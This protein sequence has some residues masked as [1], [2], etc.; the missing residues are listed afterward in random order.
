MRLMR[1]LIIIAIIIAA[2][3]AFAESVVTQRVVKVK[4]FV[5]G[6]STLNLSGK[7]N[8]AAM[9]ALAS[10]SEMAIYNYLDAYLVFPILLNETKSSFSSKTKTQNVSVSRRN[11]K[12]QWTE[13][14]VSSRY[15]FVAGN[16]RIKPDKATFKSSGMLSGTT[17]TEIEG[18][19][20]TIYDQL[21]AISGE[22]CVGALAFVPEKKGKNYKFN[23]NDN[24]FQAKV[25]VNSKGKATA[26]YKLP[27]DIAYP[28]YIENEYVFTNLYDYSLEIVGVGDVESGFVGPDQVEFHVTDNLGKFRFFSYD[29]V[30]IADDYLYLELDKDT[31]VQAVFG[32]FDASLKIIGKGSAT[33]EFTGQDEIEITANDSGSTF[34]Y[35]MVNGEKRTGNPLTISLQE[36]T[37]IQ[38]VFGTYAFRTEVIGDGSFDYEFIGPDSVKITVPE[39]SKLFRYFVVNYDRYTDRTILLD[40]WYDTRVKAVFGTYDFSVNVIGNGSVNVEFI[41][42]DTAEISVLE[43]EYPFRYYDVNGEKIVNRS[44]LLLYLQEDT[45]VEAVFGT[46]AFSLEI[47]GEGSAN[48][49]FT[50]P[51]EVE[52]KVPEGV[53]LFRYFTVNGE[54]FTDSSLS[55]SLEKD[56]VVKAVFG[57]YSLSIEVIGDGTVDYEF[58]GPDLVEVTAQGSGSTFRN[59]TVNGEMRTDNPLTISLEKDTLVKAIFGTYGLSV[60]IVGSGF[61]NVDFTDNET[62]NL[63]A[64]NGADE[65]QSFSWDGKVS[66]ETSLILELTKDTVVTATFAKTNYLVIDI[67]EGNS[68]S[69]WPHRISESGPEVENDACRTTELWLKFVPA[70]E[71]RMGSPEDE[72]GRGKRED[73]HRVTLTKGFYICVFEITRKQYELIT[74]ST[75]N[76]LPYIPEKEKDVIPAT[77]INFNTLR[78]TT[79]G[80]NWP[81]ND[82]VD[83]GSFMG[84]LRAK[85]GLRFDLPTEAQWEC[86]CRAT[87]TTA[88]NSGNNMDDE[89]FYLSEY[90]YYKKNSGRPM[91]VGKLKPNLLGLYDMH[92]NVWEWCLDWYTDNL[93]T[94]PVVDPVG[95]ETGS[96]KTLRGGSFDNSPEEC[97]SAYRA[98]TEINNSMDRLGVR[99][100]INQ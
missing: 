42:A 4:G 92:G 64:L 23:Y 97:R 100:V 88:Y 78:G 95:L 76:L 33:Y 98:H 41:D 32:T 73:A 79:E 77:K 84:I 71:F 12:F 29:G 68:A 31:E 1:Y 48:F 49:E 54:R 11:G 25:S 93:G 3:F 61:V 96:E 50:G 81:A 66:Y 47:V 17:V 6:S 37:E 44:T 13:K 46:Y 83:A 86:A 59:F 89:G 40:L 85:T 67:S 18:K 27:P 9:A 8:A 45:A 90:A 26:A 75:P 58:K 21:S 14:D 56:T 43:G 5:S 7:L 36:D 94:D 16:E 52:I 80:A 72:K 91:V 24:G 22:N 62:A 55:L 15:A 10:G 87:T 74:G 57:T 2:N 34:R 35:F 69:S 19:R 38:A 51:D 30:R 99:P 70:S 65:F 28:A 60:E 39:D 20:F 53:A 63:K 82:E